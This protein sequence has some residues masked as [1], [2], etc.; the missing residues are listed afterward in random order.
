MIPFAAYLR[1]LRHRHGL[2]QDELAKLVGHEQ[3]YISALELGTKGPPPAQFFERLISALHLDQQQK[4]ELDE[5]RRQS[6][7][8][9]S[10]SPDAPAE[11]YRMCNDLWAQIDR[12]HPAQIR[13]IQEVIHMPAALS[14]RYMPEP[15]RLRRRTRRMEAE[16]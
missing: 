13:M 11:I 5:I 4:E 12:M 10:L 2:H 16:M 15:G 14:E 9:F 7:R 6:Q 1:N 8:H 3:G